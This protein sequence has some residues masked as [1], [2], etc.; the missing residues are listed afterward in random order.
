MV[1]GESMSIQDRAD[2]LAD[3]L[4]ANLGGDYVTDPS[5]AIVAALERERALMAQ[6]IEAIREP[7]TIPGSCMAAAKVIVAQ[8]A[9]LAQDPEH[10]AELFSDAGSREAF[11]IQHAH[12]IAKITG[13]HDVSRVVCEVQRRL[14]VAKPGADVSNAA[15]EG[16]RAL[17]TL[18]DQE[19]L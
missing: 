18:M 10:L 9:A 2:D 5:D 12:L 17:A 1:M 7:F 19:A 4:A 16:A 3:D 13:W 15:N 6:E 11:E 14:A 8:F